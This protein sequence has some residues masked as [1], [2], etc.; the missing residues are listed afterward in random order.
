MSSAQSISLFIL[1]VGILFSNFLF[2][3]FLF[4]G[5][6]EKNSTPIHNKKG[7]AFVLRIYHITYTIEVTW[8][9][10][11]ALMMWQRI[12]NEKPGDEG[13]S[14]KSGIKCI[15]CCDVKSKCFSI[16]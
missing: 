16:G 13:V 12:F 15:F 8:I 9:L 2:V 7:K 6:R 10:T 5:E 4:D 3:S 1:Y 11:Y 14:I